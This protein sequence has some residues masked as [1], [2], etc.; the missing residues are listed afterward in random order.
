MNLTGDP[1]LLY[2]PNVIVDTPV[3]LF[4]ATK[5][6]PEFAFKIC[7]GMFMFYILYTYFI[8]KNVRA[9]FLRNLSGVLVVFSS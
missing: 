4:I 9:I 8:I 7:I 3:L 1:R 6:L 2:K 5:T